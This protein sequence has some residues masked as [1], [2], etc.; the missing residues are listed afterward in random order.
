MVPIVLRCSPWPSFLLL[1]FCR[2]EKVNIEKSK[3]TF[4][5]LG[6]EFFLGNF[7]SSQNGDHP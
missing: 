5:G 6:V 7:V 3:M 1:K 4:Y 2:N